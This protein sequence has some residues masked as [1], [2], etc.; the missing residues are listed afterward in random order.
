M[1]KEN[2]LATRKGNITRVAMRS[3]WGFWTSSKYGV[4]LRS[5][6]SGWE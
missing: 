1:R 3:M 4:T 5:A 6:V 2:E